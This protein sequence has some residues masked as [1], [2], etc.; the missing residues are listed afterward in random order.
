MADETPLQQLKRDCPFTYEQLFGNVALFCTSHE[1]PIV[2][3]DIFAEEWVNNWEQLV[4]LHVFL[5]EEGWQGEEEAHL[6]NN[7]Y[8]EKVAQ[9]TSSLCRLIVQNSYMICSRQAE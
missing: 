3:E 7:K 5:I 4:D 6:E 9:V 1:L 2:A 8:V